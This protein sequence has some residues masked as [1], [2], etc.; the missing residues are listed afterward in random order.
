MG[1]NKHRVGG[2]RVGARRSNHAKL[3]P[4]MLYQDP[5]EL[6]GEWTP[7]ITSKGLSTDTP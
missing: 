4:H 3:L 1:A 2:D 6:G 5:Q 7:R